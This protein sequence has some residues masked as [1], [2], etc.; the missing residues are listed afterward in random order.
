MRFKTICKYALLTL[1]TMV[2]AQS[3]FAQMTVWSKKGEKIVLMEDG[4]WEYEDQDKQAQVSDAVKSQQKQGNIKVNTKKMTKA[5]KKAYQQYMKD[6]KRKRE[7]QRKLAKQREREAEKARKAA[8]KEAKKLAKANKKSKNTKKGGSSSKKNSKSSKKNK[9]SK[10]LAD[11]ASNTQKSGQKSKGAKTRSMK[12]VKRDFRPFKLPQIV[13]PNLECKYSMN[14]VD[15]FTRQKKV[16][17]ETQFFFGYTH[18]ELRKYLRGEDYL[19]CEGYISEVANIRALHL[20]FIIDS[21]TAQDDYG[22]I[23][24]GSRM[25]VNLLDGNTV[26]LISEENN[27]GRVD[28]TNKRTVYKTYFIISSKDAKKLRKSEISQVR[29]IWSKGFEDYEVF[30]VDFL[31]SQLKCLEEAK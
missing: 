16:A 4:S 8:E 11:N 13:V 17:T 26:T 10:R 7:I 15:I 18:P 14:E 29:M 19:T 27:D 5:E 30:E 2:F 20:K 21:P 9:N 28:R 31:S 24:E 22:S 1:L 12:V 3:A 6:T 23:L 25:L